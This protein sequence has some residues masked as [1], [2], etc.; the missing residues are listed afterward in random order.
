MQVRLDQY[1]NSWYKPG[2]AFKRFAWHYINGMF[3]RSGVF[4]FYGL[5]VFLLR[6]F[7]AKIGKGVLIKPYVNIKYPWFL[8]IG[9]HTWIGENVWIDN[10]GLV[11]I[12]SQVCISQ[13]A[14]LL[15]GNHDFKKTAF[16]LMVKN[17]TI[18][19]GVWIGAKSI[20]C[21]GVTCKSHSVLSAGSVLSSDM[22]ASGI[23]RGNPATKIADRTL[24]A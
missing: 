1:N 15:T 12:G 23:Y 18:E 6:S 21:P 11:K 14:Y 19:E 17:I 20:V 8:Q 2:S 7:G 5:K 10:L 22:E 9:D 4:P 16:D 13:G 3:F 24:T